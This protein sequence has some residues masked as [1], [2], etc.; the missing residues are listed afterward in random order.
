LDDVDAPT[1][2]FFCAHRENIF[3]NSSAA[4]GGKSFSAAEPRTIRSKAAPSGKFVDACC[5]QPI[6]ARTE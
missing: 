3:R 5:R 6:R 4:S 1:E 2:E